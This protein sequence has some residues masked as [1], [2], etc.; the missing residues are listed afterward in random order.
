MN[1]TTWVVLFFAILASLPSF[2]AAQSRS[3]LMKAL[4]SEDSEVIAAARLLQERGLLRST[5]KRSSTKASSLAFS[6]ADCTMTF[7]QHVLNTALARNLTKGLVPKQV[8]EL[9][10]TFEAAGVRLKG[11]IDGPLF[12]N[13]SFDALVELRLV[14]ENVLDV[15]VVKSKVGWFDMKRFAGFVYA[16]VEGSIRQ[17]F[18]QFADCR[19]MGAADDGTYVI[20]VTFKPAG[21][22]PFVGDHAK[23][24]AVKTGAGELRLAVHLKR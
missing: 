7:R 3:I 13:P 18:G 4:H 14:R 12:V 5:E 17:H 23:L 9:V 15:L 1:K 24:T 11:K 2:A 21:F 8:Q 6:S 16:Y 19:D 20:R 22:A 10:A